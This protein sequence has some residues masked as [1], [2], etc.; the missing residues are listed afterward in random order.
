MMRIALVALALAVY[1]SPA[2]AKD[3]ADYPRGQ[4]Y[5]DVGVKPQHPVRGNT[6]YR[7]EYTRNGVRAWQQ[8]RQRP[9]NLWWWTGGLFQPPKRK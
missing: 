8:D 6:G 5:N 7:H 3:A 1:A 2:Q 4:L 9:V